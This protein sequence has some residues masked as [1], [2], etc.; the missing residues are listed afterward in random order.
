M[1]NFNNLIILPFF[2]LTACAP[3]RPAAE[4]PE[5]KVMP[6]EQRKAKTQTVSSWEIRGAMAAK[7]KAKGWST[8]MN[9]I[10]S[11]PSTYQIRLMGP[12]GSRTVL[13]DKKGNTITFQDGPKKITS[14]NADELLAE[15]TGIKLPVNNLYY[16]VR[17]LPAPGPVEAEHHDQYNH[18][19]QIKQS[20]YTINFNQYT[21]E[22]GIDLPSMIHVEGNG[23]TVKVVIKKWTV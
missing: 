8:A 20:G 13:I 22:K 14:H 10:Q 12:L 6:L 11:G 3:P 9:W 15:Q 17:G 21:S 18:L 16:W 2:L 19:T 1:N 4:L 7:N 5:N 23:V